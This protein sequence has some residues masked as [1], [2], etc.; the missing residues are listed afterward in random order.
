M[1]VVRHETVGVQAD[2]VL[3]PVPA[4]PFKV[5]FIVPPST[6]GFLPVIAAHDD[7]VEKA[8]GKEAR[9]TGHSEVF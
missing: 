7:V 3:L 8:G 9:T 2:F 4:K 6:E 1:D 5:G